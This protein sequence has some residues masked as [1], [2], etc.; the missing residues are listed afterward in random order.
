MISF[1]PYGA[2]YFDTRTS[3][4]YKQSN[5]V[6]LQY[7]KGAWRVSKLD[8]EYVESLIEDGIFQASHDNKRGVLVILVVIAVAS[9]C[10]G[11][12]WLF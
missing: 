7:K 6:W 12:E 2:E 5:K 8:C 11:L 1:M 3:T 10:L 4:Y 9:S